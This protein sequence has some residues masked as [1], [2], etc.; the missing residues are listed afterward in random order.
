M[1]TLHLL[2]HAKAKS[3]PELADIDRPLAEQG[4]RDADTMGL[5]MA[6]WNI[7]PTLILASAAQRARETLA[8]ILPHLSE[9]C[10]I[11]VERTLYSFN[12]D[13]VLSRLKSVPKPHETV[14]IVGHNPAME[15][16][17]S[18]L[19]SDGSPSALNQL[20][21]QFPTC[22]LATLEFTFDEWASIAPKT[23]RLV[24]LSVPGES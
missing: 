11:E 1:V 7:S 5:R 21:R 22:A 19:A 18:A 23:G 6:E 3:A 12:S 8:G 4:H 14:L 9:N 10:T 16:M 20:S 15:Q 2:R 24:R 13:T 17:T